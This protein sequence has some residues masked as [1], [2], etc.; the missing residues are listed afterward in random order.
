MVSSLAHESGGCGHGTIESTLSAVDRT[1]ATTP[2]FRPSGGGDDYANFG[3]PFFA[4]GLQP[5]NCPACET[6]IPPRTTGFLSADLTCQGG[7]G[8]TLE[9]KATLDLWGFMLSG[10]QPAVVC[11]G[12]CSRPP[13]A[14]MGRCEVRNGTIAAP[15]D[16]IIGDRVT[17]RDMTIDGG[18]IGT[19][20]ISFT[21]AARVDMFDSHLDA[22][23]VSAR[24]VQVTGSTFVKSGVG[25]NRV[26]LTSSTVTKTGRSACSL[27]ASSSSTHTSSAMG[28]IA[29]TPSIAAISSPS[30][31]R[32]SMPPRRATRASIS[33]SAQSSRGVLGERAIV[34]VVEDAVAVDVVPVRQIADVANAVV[35]LVGLGAVGGERAVVRVVRMAVVIHV[36]IQRVASGRASFKK[37]GT[38]ARIISQVDRALLR[39]TEAA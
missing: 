28:P 26:S 37:G 2:W 31:G 33:G 23:G 9:Q 1:T 5:P 6:R 35:V 21:S 27:A 32:S 36:D 29:P 16:S 4:Y 15:F 30:V 24:G 39:Q 13:C 19:P 22:A 11:E 20:S 25:G 7:R 18:N 38:S 14:R 34:G 8:V 10:A 17:V 12:A 3:L